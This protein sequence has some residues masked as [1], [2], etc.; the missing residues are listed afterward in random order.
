MD[1]NSDVEN[2]NY[3]YIDNWKVFYA[4]MDF[5]EIE[6]SEKVKRIVKPESIPCS[7]ENQVMNYKKIMLYLLSSYRKGVY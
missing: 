6:E 3:F 4:K 2:R 1:G 7:G 5:T